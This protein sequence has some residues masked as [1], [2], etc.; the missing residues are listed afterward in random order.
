MGGTPDQ[1]TIKVLPYAHPG[2]KVLILSMVSWDRFIQSF[3]SVTSSWN[4]T[5]TYGYGIVLRVHVP[6]GDAVAHNLMYSGEI[7]QIMST[8]IDASTMSSPGATSFH[9]TL[10]TRDGWELVYCWLPMSNCRW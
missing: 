1:Y 5:G 6:R 8:W 2:F 4:I 3:T 10:S 7:P 9:I